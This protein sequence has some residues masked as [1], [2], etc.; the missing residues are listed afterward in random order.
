MYGAT[1]A[2]GSELLKQCLEQSRHRSGI[3]IARKPQPFEHPKLIW[4]NSIEDLDRSVQEFE[5]I[6]A[7]CCLGTTV[8]QAG[9][10]EAFRKVDYDLVLQFAECCKALNTGRFCVISALGASA[11]SKNFYS[12]TKGEVEAALT[13]LQFTSLRI[14]RPSLLDTPRKQNRPGERIATVLL[15]ALSPLIVGKLRQLKPITPETV[16]QAMLASHPSNS[17]AVSIISNA[18]MHHHVS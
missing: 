3:V 9:S 17:D 16:A 2:V 18:D 5:Q 15:N 10:R 1:G 6:D 7:Y 8:K 13:E 4:L 12:R 14:F 11:Q